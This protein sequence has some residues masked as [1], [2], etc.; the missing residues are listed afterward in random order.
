MDN[1]VEQLYLASCTPAQREAYEKAPASER[2]KILSVFCANVDLTSTPDNPKTTPILL[3]GEQSGQIGDSVSFSSAKVQESALPPETPP[4]AVDTG[5]Q[6]RQDFLLQTYSKLIDK[7]DGFFSTPAGCQVFMDSILA[8]DHGKPEDWESVIA[9]IE[10]KMKTFD[11]AEVEKVKSFEWREKMATARQLNRLTVKTLRDNHHRASKEFLDGLKK[12]G[13]AEHLGY[14][15]KVFF[16]GED[17]RETTLAA[18]QKDDDKIVALGEKLY[19]ST[20]EEFAAEFKKITGKTYDTKLTEEIADEHPK[21]L[22]ARGYKSSIEA[23]DKIL[24]NEFSPEALKSAENAFGGREQLNAIFADYESLG[25]KEKFEAL[26]SFAKI[27]KNS[28]QENLNQILGERSF[29]E[30]SKS[31]SNKYE[32]Y[33]NMIGANDVNKKVE[34]FMQSEALCG[35]ITKAATKIVVI[36]AVGVLTGG[37]GAV[38]MAG[39]A[40]TT[41]AAVEISNRAS[42]SVDDI[43]NRDDL[44]E[45]GKVAA[46]D[47]VTMGTA[48]GTSSKILASSLSKTGKFGALVA[49]DTAIGAGAEAAFTGDV[50]LEGTAMNAALAAAGNGLAVKFH[51][52]FVSEAPE[53]AGKYLKD[54]G[55][56]IDDGILNEGKALD[57]TQIDILNQVANSKAKLTTEE[58]N[59]LL[60]TPSLA[61]AKDV[62]KTYE[63]IKGISEEKQAALHKAEQ[64][65]KSSK[66]SRPFVRKDGKTIINT[67]NPKLIRE[68]LEQKRI[69]PGKYVFGVEYRPTLLKEGGKTLTNKQVSMLNRVVDAIN[70]DKLRHFNLRDIEILLEKNSDEYTDAIIGWR[71]NPSQL[72]G[73]KMLLKLY[74]AKN[75]D[76]TPKYTGLGSSVINKLTPENIEVFD[77]ILKFKN[78]DGMPFIDKDSYDLDEFLNEPEKTKKIIKVFNKSS[79]NIDGWHLSRLLKSEDNLF[80]DAISA[81]DKML[82]ANKC[83]PYNIKE[84]MYND[85]FLKE[86]SQMHKYARENNLEFNARCYS[87]S[88]LREEF[89][90]MLKT[91]DKYGIELLALTGKKYNYWVSEAYKKMRIES[92]DKKLDLEL[93]KVLGDEI[94]IENVDLIENV[95]NNPQKAKLLKIYNKAGMRAAY[96]K[97]DSYN[98]GWLMSI[99]YQC[100]EEQE[101]FIAKILQ[102]C[103]DVEHYDLIPGIRTLYDLDMLNENLLSSNHSLDSIVNAAKDFNGIGYSIEARKNLFNRVLNSKTKGLP[104]EYIASSFPRDEEMFCNYLKKLEFVLDKKPELKNSFSS[105]GNN[106]SAIDFAEVAIKKGLSDD[107]IDFALTHTLPDASYVE[108][109]V[110]IKSKMPELLDKNMYFDEIEFE[111]LYEYS[112][113]ADKLSNKYS[114]NILQTGIKAGY[115]INL[116][117]KIVEIEQ[118]AGELDVSTV[119]KLLPFCTDEEVLRDMPMRR[120]RELA[121]NLENIYNSIIRKNPELKDFS[122]FKEMEKAGGLKALKDRLYKAKN[123]ATDPIM[124]GFKGSQ[125]EFFY[126]M[127]PQKL[128]KAFAGFDVNTIKDGI[129]L[130]YSRAD[131]LDTI[132]KSFVGLSGVER[133]NVAKIFGFS[134]DESGGIVGFPRP[135]AN[136]PENFTAAQKESC[137]KL[138][139]ALEKFIYQNEVKLSDNPQMEKLLNS[140]IK[141]FPEFISVIGKKQHATHAYTVDVHTLKVLQSCVENPAYK[142]LSP[143]D[144][145]VLNIAVLMHDLA[146]A[147]GV[148]DEGHYE[149]SAV[150]ARDILEKL[151]I[152]PSMREEIFNLI[153]NHHWLGQVETGAIEPEQV[154]SVFRTPAEWKMAKIFADSDLRGVSDSFYDSHK[155]ALTGEKVAKI[156]NCIKEIH[157]T[158]IP[159]FS[160]KLCHHLQVKEIDGVKAVDVNDPAAVEAAFGKGLTRD[161]LRLQV[162]MF[163]SKDPHAISTLDTLC[164]PGNEGV[165]ST[166]YISYKDKRTYG[167]RKFGIICNVPNRNQLLASSCNLGSGYQRS[168]LDLI[169]YFSDPIYTGYGGVRSRASEFLCKRLGLNSEEY[170]EFFS[171]IVRAEKLRDLRNVK[172]GDKVLTKEDI[173]AAIKEYNDS[174]INAGIHNEIVTYQPQIRAF[175]ALVDSFDEVPEHIKNAAREKNLPIILFGKYEN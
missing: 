69:K 90:V 129:P 110:Q 79:L 97:D 114:K 20:A 45:I 157:S 156:E 33:L 19:S 13:W 133:K 87:K 59:D 37:A 58:L 25:Q 43:W 57:K 41:G 119:R 47:G 120:I 108:K 14:G 118:L 95:F 71:L 38:A 137:A 80:D 10:E 172:V 100:S 126:N 154:A 12:A 147:E 122:S 159:L 42:N 136:I 36:G 103:K 124:P 153:Q 109:L 35:E 89:N 155:A 92:P 52:P 62:I 174:L 30:F 145:S 98:I 61:E 163:D 171:Q 82:S 49:S 146:K 131:L 32:K 115:P 31:H 84:I 151:N 160:T 78:K 70:K 29:D 67:G 21:Y 101:K 73:D 144:K 22:K 7:E 18:L 56:L 4:A 9:K 112:L 128:Q 39:V 91:G 23:F 40:G 142:E 1:R 93:L 130:K 170:S 54:K 94:N 143:T 152:S 135:N 81:F 139:P 125:G 132:N 44:L 134:L 72:R 99:C 165:L 46:I 150:Y 5:L 161:D 102:N 28:A 86:V 68:F 60:K 3:A 64:P 16:G 26:Q 175:V 117:D 113:N 107:L 167:F 149:L 104:F 17:T 138:N 169:R 123:H 63:I 85:V 6:K 53:V 164:R 15:V 27:T 83:N 158:G 127:A 105:N 34:E 11:H 162:H 74:Q 168:A 50:T 51:R 48:V 66:F 55:F 96:K 140:I 173:K 65:F 77:E 111:R 121:G 141:E 106:M 2:K 166:S 116:L 76:G 148:V 75:I 8:G 24:A 88:G